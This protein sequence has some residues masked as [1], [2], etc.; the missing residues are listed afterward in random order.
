MD[1][2]RSKGHQYGVS[3]FTYPVGIFCTKIANDIIERNASD[4]VGDSSFTESLKVVAFAS[5][6][7]LAQIGEVKAAIAHFSPIQV[8]ASRL[9]AALGKWSPSRKEEQFE[10]TSDL[11]WMWVDIV[12][13][14]VA[15]MTTSVVDRLQ[16]HIA[17]VTELPWQSLGGGIFP[18]DTFTVPFDA[19]L[20][21]SL[22]AKAAI[23][24]LRA[25]AKEA[26][27][28]LDVSVCS[29][30]ILFRRHLT[31]G[32]HSFCIEARRAPKYRGH[33]SRFKR[34]SFTVVSNTIQYE[35]CFAFGCGYKLLVHLC[36]PRD[37]ALGGCS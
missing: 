13:H 20:K 36:L 17:I 22:A 30:D 16:S 28:P 6:S 31:E 23:V 35:R 32:F 37:L 8:S 29:A 34:F 27:G 25:E 14:G 24:E 18:V 15:L 5:G 1:N 33:Q 3:W 11:V 19:M 2:F 7:K 9:L 21:D 10:A 4:I 12:R 26:L